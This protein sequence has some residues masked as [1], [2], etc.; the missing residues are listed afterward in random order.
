VI[1]KTKGGKGMKL[2]K[3]VP[4]NDGVHYE[5]LSPLELAILK[6]E[7]LEAKAWKILVAEIKKDF[8]IKQGMKTLDLKDVML[9]VLKDAEDKARKELLSEE[10]KA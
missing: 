3:E 9:G 4:E 8:S 7:K 10:E 6:Q 1:S 2:F 5:S